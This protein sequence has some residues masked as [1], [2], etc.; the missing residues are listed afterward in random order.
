MMSLLM[1][2]I[3]TIITFLVLIGLKLFANCRHINFLPSKF[4][5]V[6]DFIWIGILSF[7]PGANIAGLIILIFIVCANSDEF[8]W[9]DNSIT[10][11]LRQ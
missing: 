2:I 8:E 1:W 3:P 10:R 11:F 7:I 4:P 5:R 6:I 9:K